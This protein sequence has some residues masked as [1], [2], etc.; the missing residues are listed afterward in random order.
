VNKGQEKYL[1][2]QKKIPNACQQ[3]FFIQQPLQIEE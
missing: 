1:N 3:Q 2:H